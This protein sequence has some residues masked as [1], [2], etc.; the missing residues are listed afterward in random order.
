VRP[1]FDA[2]LAEPRSDFIVTVSPGLTG[3]TPSGVPV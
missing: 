1:Y 2:Q 3:P